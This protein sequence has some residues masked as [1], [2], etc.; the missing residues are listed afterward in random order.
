MNNETTESGDISGTKKPI[1]DAS[2]GSRGV[3]LKTLL[4]LG[5][6]IAVYYFFFQQNLQWILLLVAVMLFH[7]A[8]HFI[9][10]KSF[11]YK[12]VK[13]FFVPF[14]GAFVSGEPEKVSQKQ[15]VITLLAG[16]VPGI[17]LGLILLGV[18]LYTQQVFYYRLSL[19]LVLLNVFNLLPISPLDGGQL[20]ENLFM[21]SGR[22]LQP[23]FL[24]LSALALFY[25]ALMT[26][27]YFILLIVWLIIVRFRSITRMNK[28][29]ASLDRDHIKYNKTYDDLSDEEYMTIRARLIQYI[30]ALK[31][32]DADSVSEDEEFV[33]SHMQK[34]L[35]DKAEADM[36]KT[37]KVVV[38]AIWIIFTLVPVVMFL[39]YV[40][41]YRII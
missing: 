28:I 34:L 4:S 11:G 3:L 5:L 32:Y 12:D 6:Y 22:L 17:F 9:A 15:R 29:R 35:A 37:G 41:A 33:V 18:F 24:I 30:P 31:D 19:I 7:E 21:R 10:M 14:L 16:P 36:S 13:M 40:N 25:M 26:L 1:Y 23:I 8:G 38:I 27:N 39:E 2:T 20:L